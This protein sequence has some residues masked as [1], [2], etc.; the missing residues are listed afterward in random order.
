MG[1]CRPCRA[2]RPGAAVRPRRGCGAGRRAGSRWG[3]E[4]AACDR[5]AGPC[6]GDRRGGR[7]VPVVERLRRNV[8]A[9]SVTSLWGDVQ[10]LPAT[11]RVLD[12]ESRGG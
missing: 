10:W 2:G 5:E 1:R 6:A 9:D 3:V 7:A 11:R 8:D 4:R 12:D